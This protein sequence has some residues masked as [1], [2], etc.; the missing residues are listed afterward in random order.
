MRTNGEI[1]LLIKPADMVRCVEAQ[2]MRRVGQI[3]GM[4]T[5]RTVTI[6]KEWGPTAVRRV[7]GEEGVRGVPGNMK[8]L[9]WIKMAMDREARKRTAQQAGRHEVL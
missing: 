2:R 3:V 8:I 7:R 1:D 6:M 4:G 5:E 9:N